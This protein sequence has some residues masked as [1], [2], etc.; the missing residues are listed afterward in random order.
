MWHCI[1]KLLY[2]AL[3]FQSETAAA[4]KMMVIVYVIAHEGSL[5]TRDTIS[6]NISNPPF[7]PIR[8]CHFDQSWSSQADSFLKPN[9]P[10]NP[11]LLLL[12]LCLSPTQTQDW[13]WALKTNSNV[14]TITCSRLLLSNT[15]KGSFEIYFSLKI[16]V[17]HSRII[18]KNHF[19]TSSGWNIVWWLLFHITFKHKERAKKNINMTN[20]KVHRLSTVRGLAKQKGDRPICLLSLPSAFFHCITLLS[21][22]RPIREASSHI[23]EVES[24]HSFTV[25]EK[26]Q[27]V[28]F[29]DRFPLQFYRSK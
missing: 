29:D 8:I 5:I 4:T 18:N 25:K 11:L 17:D 10:F 26:L 24:S 3:A 6:N 27:F 7:E 16:E 1:W 22:T 15:R 9:S 19:E 2:P 12:L 28:M 20:R 14:Q 23:L 13:N 21:K